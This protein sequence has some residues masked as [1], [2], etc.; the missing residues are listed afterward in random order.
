VLRKDMHFLE[1][2]RVAVKKGELILKR[3]PKRSPYV[4]TVFNSSALVDKC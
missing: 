1:I 2:G 3:G 4:R